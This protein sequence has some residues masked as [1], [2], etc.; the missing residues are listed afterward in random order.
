MKK[1]II[2]A[3]ICMCMVVAAFSV[4]VFA[5]NGSGH[6]QVP[7]S[8][9]QVL[10]VKDITRTKAYSYAKVKADSVTPVTP[11]GSDTFTKCKARLFNSNNTL[12]AITDWYTLTEGK[13]YT[14]LYIYEGSLSQ[15]KFDLHFKGNNSN[16]A[17][18]I[19]F[20]YKGL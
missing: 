14:K 10:A 19:Y 5:S 7:K 1:R 18:E 2:N 11:Y 4:N 20:S 15:S 12:K 13:D 8:G 6:V 16:Y 9:Y 17:A 3:L